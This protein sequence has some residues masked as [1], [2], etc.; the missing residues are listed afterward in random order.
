MGILS[1]G[2][3]V[4]GGSPVTSVHVFGPSAVICDIVPDF[5]ALLRQWERFTAVD[6]KQTKTGLD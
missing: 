1:Y 6:Q 3:I 5:L 4:P 2:H